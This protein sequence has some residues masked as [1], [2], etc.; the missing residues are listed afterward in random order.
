MAPAKSMNPRDLITGGILGCLEAASL[1]MPF[2]VWKTHMGTYRNE[3]TIEAFK[4]VYKKN[5]IIGFW[6][7]LSPK[8][9]EAFLKGGMLLF[10]KEAII[11]VCLRMG[12]GES[13]AGLIGGA[14]GGM[15]QVTILGPCT[16]LVTAAVTG[17]KSVSL[18]QRIAHTYSTQGVSGFYRGG[19]A[20]ALR[21]ASNW[22]S[23][24][25][26]TDI[27]RATLKHRVY[28][29]KRARLSVRDEA[30]SGIL[31]GTLSVW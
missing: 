16:F 23:R 7:G 4:N 18:S 11:K 9:V 19:T 21:Q 2:E 28:G 31:G 25:G 12:T 13:A 3:T 5:G 26:F 14:G 15:A 8:M 29:D 17:D 30:I 20:L 22:A 10:S 1:G 6:K 27:I 24:Q